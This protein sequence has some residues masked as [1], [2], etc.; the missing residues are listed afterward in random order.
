MKKLI[1]FFVVFVF[2]SLTAFAQNFDDGVE[3]VQEKGRVIEIATILKETAEGG[4]YVHGGLIEG[5]YE[6]QSIKVEVLSGENEGDIVTVENDLYGNPFDVVVEEGYEVFLYAQL[7]DGQVDRYFIRDLWH[8]DGLILWTVIF[9]VFVLLIGGKSGVKA[10]ASLGGSILLIFF[11]SLPLVTRGVNPVLVTVIVSALIILITHLIITGVKKKSW[12]AMA[13]TLGG[14]LMAVLLVYLIAYSSNLT[15]MGTED[16]R[17]LALNKA[18]LDFR[19]LLFSGIILGALGAVMDIGMSISSGLYEVKEH[20]PNISTRAL[21]KSGF[22]IGR[23]ILGSMINTLIFAY[24]GSALVSIILFY[25]LKTDLFELFNYGFIAEEI[26]RSLVGAMGLLF[27]IPL[28]AVLAGVMM[29][30][31]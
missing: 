2:G 13:G 25:H 18:N 27:T 30:K 14:V 21:I 20:K 31:K 1:I 7:T 11:V 17:I 26:A 3:I 24:I 12:V 6:E 15:G 16:S 8:S 10:I 9:L 22:N 29:G 28:T 4:E 5:M 19:G 23:D